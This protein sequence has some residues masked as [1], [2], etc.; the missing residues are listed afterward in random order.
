MKKFALIKDG[1]VDNIIVA[2][3]YEDADALNELLVVESTEEN[4][5][6]VG[7]GYDGTTFKQPE[8][9]PDY[10]EPPLPDGVVLE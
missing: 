5:A 7:L 8:E 9:D 2:E 4:T 10:I 3:S 6:H 1:V